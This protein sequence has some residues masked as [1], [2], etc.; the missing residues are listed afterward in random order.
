MAGGALTRGG[1]RLPVGLWSEQE[2][3]V[4]RVNAE[5]SSA[6]REGRVHRVG[7]RPSRLAGPRSSHRRSPSAR[8][9]TFGLGRVGQTL[10]RIFQRRGGGRSQRAPLA[11]GDLRGSAAGTRRRA[12]SET[13]PLS[14]IPA[15]SCVPPM[16]GSPPL[17]RR[18]EAS[19]GRSWGE[20]RPTLRPPAARDGAPSRPD[21]SR[22]EP[23]PHGSH[24]F[25]PGRVGRTLGRIF[26]SRGGGNHPGSSPGFRHLEKIPLIGM[27][28][29]TIP[30]VPG[31]TTLR[32]RPMTVHFAR[33]PPPAFPGYLMVE[34]GH[35]CGDL[36]DHAG[37]REK[38]QDLPGLETLR[39]NPTDWHFQAP[40]RSERGR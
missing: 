6:R 40:R 25:G 10:G 7:P 26:P 29:G 9:H 8:F 27:P 2:L 35:P 37:N 20:R 12:L 15:G 4:V 21:P 19:Q 17:T 28:S 39:K 11:S 38:A 36:S 13:E 1:L 23:R 16:S 3:R 22:P 33:A 5:Q 14:R 32:A 30:K 18:G 31:T 34:V 24:T